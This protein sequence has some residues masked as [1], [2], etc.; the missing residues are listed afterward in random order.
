[1]PLPTKPNPRNYTLTMKVT[2]DTY[3]EV[4][5]EANDKAS[6][7]QLLLFRFTNEDELWTSK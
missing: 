5:N 3:L 2:K 1:M 6:H 4:L 7:C